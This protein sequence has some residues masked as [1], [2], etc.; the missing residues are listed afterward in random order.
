MTQYCTS[1][2]LPRAYRHL[3]PS[4]VTLTRS[5]VVF[6]SWEPLAE[7]LDQP[8]LSWTTS[9]ATP[10]EPRSPGTRNRAEQLA[11]VALQIG[12]DGGQPDATISV[13]FTTHSR[14]LPTGGPG[15]RRSHCSNRW[16]QMAP[17]WPGSTATLALALADVD[18]TDEANQ[19]LEEFAAAG[20]DLPDD[21]CGSPQWSTAP[22]SPSHVGTEPALARCST[23]SPRGPTSCA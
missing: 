10:P 13:R 5:I 9:A 22:T 20:F 11:T 15:D 12:N 2:R 3:L 14:Q 19:L 17:I 8:I 6:A 18:R 21:R 1:W 23:G 4:T 7:Q 16:S